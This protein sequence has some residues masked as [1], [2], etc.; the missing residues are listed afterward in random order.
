MDEA[1][2]IVDKIDVERT[3][4]SIDSSNGDKIVDLVEGYS[5]KEKIRVNR[6]KKKEDEKKSDHRTH[7]KERWRS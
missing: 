4:T 2:K 7:K 1:E 6:I 3:S 5:K